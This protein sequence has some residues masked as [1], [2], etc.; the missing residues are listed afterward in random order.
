MSETN[1]RQGYL[2]GP[3]FGGGAGGAAS[4]GPA[5][6]AAA[7]QAGG[8]GVPPAGG[9]G[10][11]PYGMYPPPPPPPR[12]SHHK[13]ALVFTGVAA[14]A[15]GAAAG[16]LVNTMHTGS[17]GIA[18]ATSKTSLTASQIAARVD[19]GLVD[20][21]STDGDEEATS[22][23][24]GI[25]LTSTGEILTNNHV[26]EGS[27]SIKVVDIGTG[28]TYTAKVVG[29]DASNDVAVIQLADASGLTTASLG[30][31]TTVAVGNSVTALGN[32]EGKGGTPSVASGS[33][34]AL[35]Q[36]ITA[37]DEL[38]D[39]NE[40]LT[41]LIESNVPIQPG[42]SGGPLVNAYGQVVGMDTA[43]SSSYQFEGMGENQNDTATDAYTIPINEALQLAQDI[44]SGNAAGTI[45]IGATAFMGIETSN[46]DQNEGFG[47]Q[48][49]NGV[50]IEGAVQGTPAADVGLQQYDTITSLGGQSVSDVED[51][52]HILVK[53]HPGDSIQV[54]W[55]DQE[56][57][58]HTATMTL[59][60]GPAA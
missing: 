32:A 4:E 38:S 59:T 49:V 46:E 16:G 56:G 7:G 51:I 60:S 8:A 15:V 35:D 30:S 53:Y 47:Q 31:S 34:T 40:Q 22:Y 42:D 54:T 2:A 50:T 23:G 13:R 18:T 45:H 12:P 1:E 5:G 26:I 57:D 39:V 58:Q 48:Q 44:E 19:P 27:T 14:L 29:Y 43:A 37:S 28:K 55:V 25:V 21:I 11:H 52:Q 33:V 24:T 17:T 6:A 36:S 41:G 20:V 10:T 9:Y 3:S